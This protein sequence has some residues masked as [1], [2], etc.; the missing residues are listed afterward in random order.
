MC[1]IYGFSG[2][3]KKQLNQDLYEFYSHAAQHPNGWGLALLDKENTLV[4]RDVKRADCSA[5]LKKL[6]AYPVISKTSLAH[7][8]LATIGNEEFDNCHPFTAAD[9]SGRLWY[10][11]HNGTVFESDKMNK[12]VFIQ[13]GET[14]S[15]RLLLYLIDCIN[16]RSSEVGRP[17]TADERFA[18]LDKLVSS[19]SP[20][21]KL[22]LLI[23]DG[24]I[25]YVHTNF[26]NSLYYRK[27]DN[28]VTFST[29]PLTESG[30][31]DVKFTTLLGYR[32][33]ELVFTGTTHG[34]EYYFDP[35]TY[36]PL[37]MAYAG[38]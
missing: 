17:L 19:G 24:E 16:N 37:Y 32:N 9:S 34:N 8:R 11:I 5:Y 26:R 12:Y 21:N 31:N 13:K 22:N 7:I 15:E 30:W 23:Y 36:I 35:D 38:L 20:K 25:M 1:E 27:E 6:L 3:R 10:L 2:S 14:D 4:K 28:G 33:G 29:R 18:V